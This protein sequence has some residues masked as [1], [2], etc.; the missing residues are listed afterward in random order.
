MQ[1]VNEDGLNFALLYDHHLCRLHCD[2]RVTTLTCS[3]DKNLIIQDISASLMAI[4]TRLIVT[5]AISIAVRDT[6]VI[7]EFSFINELPS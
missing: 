7:R 3:L 2:K 6:A 1:H 5:E 4:A